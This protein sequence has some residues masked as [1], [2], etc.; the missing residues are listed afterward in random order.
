MGYIFVPLAG[1]L[2]PVLFQTTLPSL[3]MTTLAFHCSTGSQQTFKAEEEKLA[4]R[5]AEE[6]KEAEER[7]REAEKKSAKIEEMRIKLVAKAKK[8][9]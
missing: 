9:M 5:E 6:R 7:W 1:F 4:G 3:H 8:E 2:H